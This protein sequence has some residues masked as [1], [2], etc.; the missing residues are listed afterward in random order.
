[1]RPRRL[2]NVRSR[3]SG[4]NSLFF[5]HFVRYIETMRPTFDEFATLVQVVDYGGVTAAAV[6]LRL[7][8]SV[9]SKRLASLEARLGTSLF[10]RAGRRM[11]PTE[12]GLL[13][14]S[15]PRRCCRR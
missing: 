13:A 9:V 1:M 8:K 15:V 6:R 5:E 7:P 11:M 2:P 4:D 3:D 10:H 12:A 14:M